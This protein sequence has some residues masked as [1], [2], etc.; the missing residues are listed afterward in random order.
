VYYPCKKTDVIQVSNL[1]NFPPDLLVTGNKK[2]KYT[3]RPPHAPSYFRTGLV[4]FY[5]MNERIILATG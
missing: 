1:G 3:A 5:G 4:Q 2:I